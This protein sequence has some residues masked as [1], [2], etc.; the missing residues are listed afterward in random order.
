MSQASGSQDR[1][2]SDFGAPRELPKWS[3]EPLITPK[4]VP[5]MVPSAEEAA[6]TVLD[7]MIRMSPH[8]VSS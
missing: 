7:V 2:K 1:F 4:T 5:K 6:D 8:L 3:Q